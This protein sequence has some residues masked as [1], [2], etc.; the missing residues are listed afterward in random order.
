MTSLSKVQKD[1]TSL[2]INKEENFNYNQTI[3]YLSE[4]GYIR[5]TSIREPGEFS[6]KGDVIDLFPS[7]YDNPVRLDSFGDTIEKLQLFNLTD[8]K[9]INDLKRVIVYPFNEFVFNQNNRKINAD[10]FLTDLSTYELNDLI[11]HVDHGIG[12]FKGLKTISVLGSNHDCVEIHYLN[13]DKLFIPVE[14]IELLSKYGGKNDLVVL[15][16]LGATQWQY[17]KAVAKNKIKETAAE[18]IK[19]AASR[20]LESAPKFHIQEPYYSNFNAEFPFDETE[21]QVNAI[22]EIHEDL[23]KGTPMDRLICGDVGFGKTEVALRAAFTVGL[24]G[25]QVAILV[26]TTLLCRQHFEN[27][28]ERFKKSPIK[29]GQLSRLVSKKESQQTIE[30]VANGEIDILIGTHSILSE[31][32][33]F[34]KMGL[35]IIDEEQH[36]GVKQKEKLKKL[37]TNVHILSL[38]ATPIPRTLQMSLVGLRELSI[39]STAPVNRQSIKT[40][41]LNFDIESIKEAIINEVNRNGQLYY[42]CPRVNQIQEVEDFLKSELPEVSYKIAHGQMP[43]KNLENVMVDFYNHEFSILLCTTIVESGLDLRNTNTMIIHNSDNFG[44]SQLYQLRGRI[45]R[46]N[47]E[48]FCYYTV[49]DFDALTDQAKQRLK[50]LQKLD[51]LGSG[52]NLA[53]HDLD[54]RGSGNILGDDQS[55]HIREIGLELYHRLLKEKI[56]ELQDDGSSLQSEWSPQINLGIGVL[57]PTNYIGS[58]NTRLSFYRKLAYLKENSKIQDI[59][60]EMIT[61]FGELPAEVKNLF[62]VTELRSLC[63]KSNIEKIDLGQKGGSIKFKDNVFTNP[64]GLVTLIQLHHKNV[65][66]RPDQSLIYMF[67]IPDKALNIKRLIKL[68]EKISEL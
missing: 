24:S 18:L 60:D 35:L 25:Y 50:L 8:Q 37:R 39:I 28:T 66:I 9:S 19:T 67:D 15:D 22:S 40:K 1:E 26:P 13:D 38:T 47:T 48:A 36:F 30:N 41:V 44:L 17:R 58:L 10:S 62:M 27:L 59:K 42:V 51:S 21:D 55:G 6:V 23:A 46:S 14:N 20:T 3:S 31:K 53:S 12:R 32:I 5:V 11:V 64:E 16:R 43:S 61:T 29:I 56:N 33:S 54:I 4:N 57:I 34:K 2:I 63:K 65:K 7:D 52:F 49:K 45:G 68:I